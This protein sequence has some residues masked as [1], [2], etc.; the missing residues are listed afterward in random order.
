MAART[1]VRWA[2]SILTGLWV[3]T[4]AAVPIGFVLLRLIK[5]RN[6]GVLEPELL[7]RP[8]VILVLLGGYGLAAALGGWS[9]GWM[10]IDKHRRL[11]VLLGLSHLGTWLLAL[12]AGVVPFPTWFALLLAVTAMVGS[13]AGVGLRARQAGR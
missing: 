4:G 3:T 10:T 6:E 1:Y 12:V 5:A 7:T 2:A 11:I 9:A 13:A 8:S